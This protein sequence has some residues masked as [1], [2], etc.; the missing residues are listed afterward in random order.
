MHCD[1]GVGSGR[2]MVALAALA[3]TAGRSS[4]ATRCS[5]RRIN[6]LKAMVLP[7][8]LKDFQ[9]DVATTDEMS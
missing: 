4:P 3:A 5:R 8:Y 2:D 1:D 7:A 6:G 9:V